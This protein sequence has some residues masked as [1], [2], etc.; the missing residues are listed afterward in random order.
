M[1][2]SNQTIFPRSP[3][4]SMAGWV[5]LPRFVDKIRLHLAGKLGSD[6]T[7]NFAHKGF[8]AK[9]LA[10]AGLKAEDFIKVVGATITDGEVCDWVER[11]VNPG[12]AHSLAAFNT[13]ALN[14][15]RSGDA[16][17]VA[18][19]KMRKEAAGAAHRDDIDTFFAVIDA[20]EKRI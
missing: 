10:A 20:D 1:E 19:L 2:T 4:E 11:H 15:G 8:D 16:E 12:R 14:F 9:W 13:H 7:G 17:L 18:R 6:Y 5:Y 3:L